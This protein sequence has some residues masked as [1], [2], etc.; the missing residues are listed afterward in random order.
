M[1]KIGICVF[2]AVTF[3]ICT[4]NAM[5]IEE[6]IYKVIVNDGQF[7]IR[8]Y[9]SYILAEVVVDATLEESGNIA[10]NRLFRYISGSNRSLAKIPMT[11]PVSQE[12]RPEKI[13]MT[14]P[15]VQQP[16]SGGWTISFTMPASY[17][18][19]T[20][21][22]PDDQDIKLRQVPASRMVAIRYSGFWSERN[23]LRNKEALVGWINKR[24]L[25]IVRLQM[26][27]DKLDQKL[28]EGFSPHI[29]HSCLS[30]KFQK[31]VLLSS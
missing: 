10:F 30:G 2:T 29:I 24:G 23:Y 11:V 13:K 28:R 1:K 19:G 18:M 21:P 12:A 31:A 16:A 6:A 20:L 15:V 22:Q 26:V 5:A 27:L 25:K 14:A 17:S 3:I 7:E 4:V 9:A 8:D